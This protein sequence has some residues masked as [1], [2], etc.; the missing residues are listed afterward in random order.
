MSTY[1][2]MSRKVNIVMPERQQKQAKI[3]P[4]LNEYYFNLVNSIFKHYMN[5]NT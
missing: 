2:S 3:T 1:P 4:M 5:A